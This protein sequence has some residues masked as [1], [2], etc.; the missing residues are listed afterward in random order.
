MVELHELLTDTEKEK[1]SSIRLHGTA[2]D[3][4]IEVKYMTIEQLN[5]IAFVI[6]ASEY[7][8][9]VPEC[10]LSSEVINILTKRAIK[11]KLS[12]FN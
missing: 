4:S 12:I 7:E 6:L 8:G 1:L 3:T 9:K 11:K 2:F 5:D 10:V